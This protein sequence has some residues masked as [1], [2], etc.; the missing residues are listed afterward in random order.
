[1]YAHM[2]MNVCMQLSTQGLKYTCG[3]GEEELFSS[4][5]TVNF[6]YLFTKSVFP[7][8]L[9]SFQNTAWNFYLEKKTLSVKLLE[10]HM[11][12]NYVWNNVSYTVLWPICI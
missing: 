8:M 3:K 6:Y 11:F 10:V 12:A 9:V 4:M 1:M 7:Y 2:S 5:R